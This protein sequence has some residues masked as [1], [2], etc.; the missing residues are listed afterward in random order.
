MDL[1]KL[2][3]VASRLCA[4]LG[5]TAPQYIDNG[6]SAAVYATSTADGRAA[7]K[8]YD[9]EFFEGDNALIETRR[10]EL[11]TQLRNHDCENLIE[12]LAADEVP[13]DRTWYLLM[14]FCPWKSLERVLTKV[15]DDKVHSLIKQLV[16]AVKF[17]DQHELVH[18]DIKPANIVV[19]DDFTKLKLLDFGVM[20]KV[21]FEEG[22]GTDG[23]KFIATAQYS[24]PEYLLR[25]EQ[26][27]KAGFDA[28]NI[29][30]VG[31]VLHDLITKTAL[32]AEEK[33]T[34]NKFILFK[35]VTEKVPR[36]ISA[37]VPSRLI[38]LCLAALDKNPD[39]RVASVKLEDF[40]ADEDDLDSIRRR[41]TNR[42][43]TGRSGEK[44]APLISTWESKVRSWG[45]LAAQLE[46]DA[47]GAV[48]MRKETLPTGCRWTLNFKGAAVPV[49]LD[50]LK[51]ADTLEIRVLAKPDEDSRRP[52]AII[53][54]TGVNLPESGIAG[55][56]SAEY[57]FAL[58][59]A[60]TDSI[61]LADAG[62]KS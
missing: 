29:Y 33:E 44:T 30:Q 1:D 56:L 19:S 35:A 45:K 37:S 5:W 47:L 38:A 12:V 32:F 57:L 7:L 11:Q 22:S 49:Y 62:I 13:E 36:I 39:T 46:S 15:P 48:T 18:R 54:A 50:L 60:I 59:R 4:R 25:Q 55:M 31:G 16:N 53:D 6:A 10:I 61:L 8:I 21:A 23:Y 41:V 28:I 20:R 42:P 43:S 14:E 17:M 58:E 2:S 27:G 3:D 34:K 24:P 9:P 51:T 52:I 26:P 40:I